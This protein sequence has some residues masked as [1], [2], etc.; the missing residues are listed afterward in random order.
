MSVQ[1]VVRTLDRGNDGGGGLS[2]YKVPKVITNFDKS[3]QYG[4][5]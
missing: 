3:I 5:P 1:D 4:I 2:T